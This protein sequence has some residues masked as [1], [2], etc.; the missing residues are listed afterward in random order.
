MPVSKHTWKDTI[1]KKKK[2]TWKANTQITQSNA[3]LKKLFSYVSLLHTSHTKYTLPELFN[4][5]KK[6]HNFWSQVDKNLKKSICSLWFW[7]TC[8]LETRSRSPNLVWIA[9]PKQGYN[10]TRFEEPPLPSMKKPT[11]KFFVKSGNTSIISFEYVWKSKAVVYSWPASC[12]YQSS[13][14]T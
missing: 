14:S 3:K 5:R 9:R 7:H 1:S 2:R 4:V 6:K 13:V 12:T 8:D 10:N 11:I